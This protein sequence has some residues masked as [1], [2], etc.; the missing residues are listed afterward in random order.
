MGHSTMSDIDIIQGDA[1][2]FSPEM[3]A[4]CHSLICDPP[5]SA[6]V[7]ENASSVG[8][9]DG[10]MGAHK[11]DFGFAHLS[12]ELRLHAASIAQ[13][14]QGYSCLFSD[15]Q[16][17]HLLDADATLAGAECIRWVPWVR[18]S[19]PQLSGDRPGSGS[20]A[21]CLYHRQNVGARGGRKPVAK[22]W[23]GPGSL[24]SFTRRCLRGKEKHPTE[25][26]L[27]LMLD[28][29]C[30]FTQ[31]GQTVVD[32]TAGSFTTAQACRLLGRSCIAIEQDPRWVAYGKNRVTGPLPLRDLERAKEWCCSVIDEASS[33]PEPRAADG[34]D[35]KTYERAQRRL[36]DALAVAG[37]L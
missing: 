20:E 2:D 36:A 11:R 22:M 21:V 32:L 4:H 30:Y 26:P 14:V 15:W 28:L 5:Y 7:H 13:S 1:L 33:V 24:T 31:P 18:W 16:S 8:I 10:G 23:N 37:R 34:S 9:P 35:V 12:D 19:Q 29:V 17:A 27:D 6:R 25:K 3:A